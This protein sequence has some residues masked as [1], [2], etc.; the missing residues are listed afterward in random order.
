MS[1]PEDQPPSDQPANPDNIAHQLRILQP[2]PRGMDVNAITASFAHRMTYSVA[3]DHYTA[4]LLD[5]F[6]ASALSIR[7]RLMDRWFLTQD[8]YYRKDVK[9]VYYLSL[10]FLLGRSC[11]ANL[12]NLGAERQFEEALR[13][14]GY[15]STILEEHE[16]DAGLGNGGLGRLAACFLDSAST[17]ALPFYGYGIR[18]EYGIFRQQLDDGNQTEQPD[19]WLRFGNPWE[20]ARV[21]VLFLV[22]FYGRVEYYKADD[23]RDRMRWIDTEDVQAMAYDMPMAGFRNDTVN[24]LRLWTAKSTR[25]F[26]LASFNAGE[27]V[28]A[29]E[30]KTQTENISKVLYP[31]DDRYA[32]R[33]PGRDPPLH[34]AS[35]PVVRTSGQS[36]HSAQRHASRGGDPGADARAGRRL[37]RGVGR[38]VGDHAEGVRL[39]QPYGAA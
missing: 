5:A 14:I 11:R 4:T 29:V 38:G 15:D 2:P 10:E 8:A 31:P 34:Q 26:D 36:R 33:E 6:Q 28:K 9:R 3:R 22:K 39:H 23:G 7:D 35:A 30:N 19:S 21:D 37:P 17:L 25:E 32:G 12:L 27:Y 18:Y 24:S 16:P 1:D 13:E 20:V